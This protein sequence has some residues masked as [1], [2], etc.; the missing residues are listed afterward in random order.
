L[1]RIVVGSVILL[2]ASSHLARSS[3]LF[4]MRGEVDHVYEL[5]RAGRYAEAEEEARHAA[6]TARDGRPYDLAISLAALAEAH[7]LNGHSARSEAIEAARGAVAAAQAGG[8]DMPIHLALRTLGRLLADR[9]ELAEAV[10]VLESALARK[11]PSDQ[12][13]SAL[14]VLQD[15][16]EVHLRRH[17][18]VQAQ[19]SLV[20][21]E[22]VSGPISALQS[23]RTLDLRARLEREE[24]RYDAAFALGEQAWSLRVH[25]PDAL[26]V[27]ESANLLGELEWFRRRFDSSCS[28]HRRAI[29]VLAQ[30]VG[31]AHPAYGTSLGN[32][33]L[34]EAARG[35]VETARSLQAHAFEV[36]LAARGEAHPDTLDQ[37][38]NLANLDLDGGDYARARDGYERV[39]RLTEAQFGAE[40]DEAANVLYNLGLL[41]IRGGDPAGARDVLTRAVTAWEKSRGP[42][43]PY[44]A[45]GL[46]VLGSALMDLGEMKEADAA[47]ERAAVIHSGRSDT[48]SLAWTLARRGLVRS[49]LGDVSDAR[50]LAN[51]AGVLCSGQVPS[52]TGAASTLAFL[53]DL[54][55][56]LGRVHRAASYFERATK[57]YVAIVGGNHPRSAAA[58]A[59]WAEALYREGRILQALTEAEEADRMRRAHLQA[60]IRYLPE[61]QAL[62]FALRPPDARDVL[63]TIAAS[64]RSDRGVRAAQLAV[65]GSRALVLDEMARRR[66]DEE[67]SAAALRLLALRRRLAGAIFSNGESAGESRLRDFDRLRQELREAE[68]QTALQERSRSPEEQPRAAPPP[69]WVLVSFVRY[70]DV[71]PPETMRYLAILSFSD[72]GVHPRVVPLGAAP[73]IDRRVASWRSALQDSAVSQSV[74]AESTAHEAGVRLR[75]L[76]WDPISARLGRARGVL[77]VPDGSLNLVSFAGL[78][79][80]RGFV[81]E[82]GPTIHYLSAERDLLRVREPPLASGSMLAVGGPDFDAPVGPDVAGVAQTSK[83]TPTPQRAVP[84]DFSLIRRGHR[85]SCGFDASKF[86]FLPDAA[87]E[88]REVAALWTSPGRVWSA[89][90]LTGARA[91]KAALAAMSPGRAI[92]HIAT[93]GFFFGNCV[94]AN[95][96]LPTARDV[97]NALDENP[98][99][100]SGLAL[101]GANYRVPDNMEDNGI[102][103]AAEVAHLDLRAADWVV[104]SACGTGLGRIENGEGV[105]GLRRAFA[106]AGA[107]TVIM[108]LWSVPDA[109]TRQWMVAL[110]RARRD[111]LSTPDAIRKAQTTIL[112]DLRSKSGAPHAA[113]WSAFVAAGDWR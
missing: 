103:T 86:E 94:P 2:A 74:A 13:A 55:L 18:K 77:L 101:A 11:H 41:F 89:T 83:G 66:V 24:G 58:R 85:S 82:T 48:F 44:V 42:R 105:L 59:R 64:S 98:L 112:S 56:S 100:Q 49:R 91:S 60:T 106:I 96:G 12:P 16:A 26:I 72:E 63:L 6:G 33:A 10:A 113:F 14:D 80:G 93:H 54:E 81:V 90:V 65:S 87:M 92:V 61:M 73:L 37:L 76:L 27:A 78:P 30:S 68:R 47:L 25:L 108:S 7:L 46:D 1:K 15:L 4:D 9:A 39:R 22:K 32:L 52:S 75:Q 40:S 71:R 107:R 43:H 35:D 23:A 19:L 28:W 62:R 79:F 20:Q 109:I 102:V 31:T 34:A 88:A 5:L 36:T 111:G 21:V 84:N 95:K 70:R 50:N 69:G 57:T 3:T 29:E 110:Y 8:E 45:R 97:V 99:L 38:Q 67:G 17:D 104:L 51:R 53:G